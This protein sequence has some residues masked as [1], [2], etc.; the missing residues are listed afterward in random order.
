[1]QVWLKLD[2]NEGNFTLG[3]E[4]VI[5]PYLTSHFSRV[6]KTSHVA[7]PQHAVQAWQ[8]RLKSESN[9]RSFTL[10]TETVFRL[11]L[12]SHSSGVSEM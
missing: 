4:A 5:R 2:S 6:T 1:V 8:V 10:E 7:L 12:A 11:Y 3:T 9:G